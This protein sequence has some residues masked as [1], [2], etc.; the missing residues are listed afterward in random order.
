MP[1]PGQNPLSEQYFPLSG[2]GFTRG[3]Q[4]GGI[5]RY[6]ETRTAYSRQSE[7][8]EG[9]RIPVSWDEA[10]QIAR[11]TGV[12][13]AEQ[14]AAA[15]ISRTIL[16][17]TDEE[18]IN[19]I[20]Q[21]STHFASEPQL[22]GFTNLDA[23]GNPIA[24]PEILNLTPAQYQA[25]M[26]ASRAQAQTNARY[27]QLEALPGESLEQSA[28]RIGY[29][30]GRPITVTELIDLRARAAASSL[31]ESLS[32]RPPDFSVSLV[33]QIQEA[34][35]SA[36]RFEAMYQNRLRTSGPN[37]LRTESAR[38]NA[39]VTRL[40]Y[41]RLVADELRAFELSEDA[42]LLARDLAE[43]ATRQNAF[44]AEEVIRLAQTPHGRQ[45]RM[46]NPLLAA[47]SSSFVVGGGPIVPVAEFAPPRARVLP[48]GMRLAPEYG[49]NA[50]AEIPLPQTRTLPPGMS[51]SSLTRTP[52]QMLRFLYGQASLQGWEQARRAAL[53][54]EGLA[55][56]ALEQAP[57]I[58]ENVG[59][60]GLQG[61]LTPLA[62]AASRVP[63]AR[64]FHTGNAA[65]LAYDLFSDVGDLTLYARGLRDTPFENRW[66]RLLAPLAILDEATDAYVRNATA[67]IIRNVRLNTPEL[68]M[69][70]AEAIRIRN[71]REMNAR[72]IEPD[73]Y[74]MEPFPGGIPTLTREQFYD[75]QAARQLGL[76]VFM[77]MLNIQRMVFETVEQLSSPSTTMRGPPSREPWPRGQFE[78]PLAPE[79]EQQP[80]PIGPFPESEA[81][82]F[83]REFRNN[84]R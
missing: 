23:A 55:L 81:E 49:P 59:R 14:R 10:E 53:L 43:A 74:E 65:L 15:G 17:I 25:R 37:S 29:A 18:V 78:N 8:I 26:E 4:P 66:P 62:N 83:L 47:E 22:P 20:R 5:G 16:P 32:S 72:N 48:P 28:G 31:T 76:P 30:R 12:S 56:K 54:A 13:V 27:R 33:T 80:P 6:P 3:R 40:H 1:Y 60:V 35:A 38:S 70:D 51:Q 42:A 61:A 67:S 11:T 46:Q 82:R 58:F 73:A 39:L 71:L 50:I 64:L 57:S 21:I 24:D 9:L 44:L 2:T 84:S 36:N 34:R 77:G 68:R 75:R 45:L 19:Q 41:E 63:W 7:F 79:S 52:T 69:Q